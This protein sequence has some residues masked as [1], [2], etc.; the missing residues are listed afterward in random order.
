MTFDMDFIDE[1]NDPSSDTYMETAAKFTAAFKQM[2]ASTSGKVADDVEFNWRF[3]E[4]SVV[5]TLKYV[6]VS[7]V[8]SAEDAQQQLASA[9]TSS[10][11]GLQGFSVEKPKGKH[12]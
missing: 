9:D 1:L 10:I 3:T 5:G 4:G 11:S 2:L 6:P 12:C 7:C 8:D